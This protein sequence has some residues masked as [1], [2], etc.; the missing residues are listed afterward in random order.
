MP[1]QQ[2]QHN[3][4]NTTT[5]IE[6]R[7]AVSALEVIKRSDAADAKSRRVGGMALRYN[8][9]YDLGWFSEEIRAGALDAANMADVVALFNHDPNIPLARNSAGT[10]TLRNDSEGLHYEFDAPNSPNGD[11]LLESVTRGDVR[12][13]SWAFTVSDYEWEMRDGKDHRVITKIRAVYD[14]SPVTYPA[15]PD[16]TVALRS[17]PQAAPLSNNAATDAAIRVRGLLA[18]SAAL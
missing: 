9:V 14:V 6:R 7:Y 3:T 17:R 2:Q 5:D 8:V 13:S 10:L 15:N 1:H 4:A 16:T 11:N 12:A 18:G